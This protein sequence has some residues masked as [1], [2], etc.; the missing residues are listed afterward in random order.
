MTDSKTTISDFLNV[1]FNSLALLAAVAV[2]VWAF[3]SEVQPEKET[4]PAQSAAETTVEEEAPDGAFVLG[5]LGNKIREERNFTYPATLEEVEKRAQ[6]V[7]GWLPHP[8]QGG[9]DLVYDYFTPTPEPKKSIEE[10][11]ELENTSPEINA[12]IVDAFQRIPDRRGMDPARDTQGVDYNAELHRHMGADVGSFNPLFFSTQPDAEAMTYTQIGLL[13]MRKDTLE[14]IGNGDAILSW[15][16]SA[17]HL[18][19]KIVIRDDL[20]WS[21]DEPLTAYDWEFS[22]NVIMSSR[23]PIYAIRSGTD[24]LLGVKAYDEHTL[25]F[26]HQE[27]MPISPMSVSF[28]IIPR[29]IY[30]KTIAEDPTL[31]RTPYHQKQEHD[32][33]TSGPYVVEKHLPNTSIVFRRRENYYMYKGKAVREKPYINRVHFQISPDSATAF[34]QMKNGDIEVMDLSPELW[35]TQAARPDFYQRNTKASSTSWTYFALWFNM[36]AECPYFQ[37]IRVRQA[38]SM[39]FD[40]DEMLKVHRK[41]LDTQCRG[42]FAESAPFF[43]HEA[44]LPYI[45][46]DFAQ[47][48]KLLTEAGWVDSDRDGV[49]DHDWNGKRIPFSF[50]ILT[51]TLPE[52][53]ELCNLFAQSLRQLGIECNVQSIEF[54]VLCQRE[55]EHKFQMV[56]SGWGGGSDPYSS[57]NIWGTGEGRNYTSYSNKQVDELFEAGLKEFDRPKRMAIYQKI[58]ELIY[59]DYPCVWLFNRNTST[60]FSK[61]LRGVGFDFRGVVL[62]EV[63]KPEKKK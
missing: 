49:L 8:V 11:R 43:P 53:I 58:H 46:Q 62:G 17:D 42:L 28:P 33:V 37:D 9:Y 44:N 54:N 35:L 47:A 31:V 16:S 18:M 41:G 25:I 61:E 45:R 59:A 51:T 60:A 26:F 21:D 56:M 15:E 7:G 20:L 36:A 6:E 23:V 34:M 4:E 29:H 24:F 2:F 57:Q 1:L 32:P 55:Q 50:T 52:R 12:E 10:V 40:Y 48:R 14:Y 63:W 3:W 19:D 38:L 30:E 13:S 39:A 22:Y 5:D 27:A